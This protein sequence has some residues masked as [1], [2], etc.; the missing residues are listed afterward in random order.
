MQKSQNRQ[1]ILRIIQRRRSCAVSVGDLDEGP[2]RAAGLF[3][4]VSEQTVDA[5]QRWELI[6]VARRSIA[7]GTASGALTAREPP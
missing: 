2:H 5:R 4:E 3:T 7:C 6:P 1:P